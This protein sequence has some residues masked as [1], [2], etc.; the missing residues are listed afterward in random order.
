MIN[1]LPP[2]MG[3]AEHRLAARVLGRRIP[4]LDDHALADGGPTFGAIVVES[5]HDRAVLVDRLAVGFAIRF[6]LR[7][8]A[9]FADLTSLDDA[10]GELDA[11]FPG[12]ERAFQRG[13]VAGRS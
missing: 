9:V 2:P 3:D 6:A 5:D 4:V 13:R 12:R 11:P 10:V 8:R 7:G 1:P